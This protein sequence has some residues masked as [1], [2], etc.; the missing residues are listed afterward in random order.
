[1]DGE[2]GQE[3]Y[4]RNPD[5][6]RKP[7]SNTKLLT[8]AAAFDLLGPDHRSEA[9]LWST[10]AGDVVMVGRHDPSWSLYTYEGSRVALDRIAEDIQRAGVTSISNV[11]ATGE[12]LY[13]GDNFAYYDAGLHRDR[14][15][16]RALAVTEPSIRSA[17][18]PTYLVQATIDR[19]MPF[20]IAGKK[21]GVAQVLSIR[22]NSPLSRAMAQIAGTSCTSNVWVPGLS[23]KTAR[24]SGPIRSAIPAPIIGS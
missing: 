23:M 6:V 22:V 24:V 8:T 17:W 12:F 3:L 18:P 14:A 15:A 9:T 10:D 1:M 2:I 21:S 20:S 5:T 7:A 16:A 11:V 19:S 13:D 4:A